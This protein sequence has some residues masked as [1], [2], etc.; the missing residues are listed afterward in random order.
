MR[1]HKE[2][3]PEECGRIPAKRIFFGKRK[4]CGGGRPQHIQIYNLLKARRVLPE[5]TQRFLFRRWRTEEGVY[6]NKSNKEQR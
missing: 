2:S 5:K 6:I 1:K 4:E 3:E